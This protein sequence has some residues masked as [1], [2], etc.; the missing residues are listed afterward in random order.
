MSKKPSLTARALAQSG[1]AGV[2]KIRGAVAAEMAYKMFIEAKREKRAFFESPE[3]GR[4]IRQ[5]QAAAEN[6]VLNLEA[7]RNEKAGSYPFSAGEFKKAFEAVMECAPGERDKAVLSNGFIS[8]AQ[9]Y[10]GMV[11]RALTG[12]GSLYFIE[13]AEAKPA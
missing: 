12:P 3:F 4:L 6:E 1:R 11:F 2:P 8:D 9:T 5:F 7:V 10:E 13:K